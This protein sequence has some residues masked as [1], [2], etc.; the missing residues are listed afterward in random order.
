MSS[1]DQIKQ[2]R[3]ETGVSIAEC[4]KAIEETQG[5]LEKAKEILRMWGK[6]L[7]D[8]K[9]SREV[10][11]GMIKSYI[12]ANKKVGVLL[13]IRCESDFVVRNE[14]FEALAHEI[15]LQIA[16]MNP[17]FLS[18]GNIP[19]EVLEQEKKI[20][21]EQMKDSGKPKEIVDQIIDGKLKKFKQEKTL[22]AQAWIKDDTK[23]I[24]DLITDYIGKIGENIIVKKFVRYEI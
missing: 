13:D 14:N 2:L 4:K 5:D 22:L 10:K 15:C 1:L 12:H 24:T 6:S 17:E 11:A 3:E 8:K 7:A 19:A 18:E 23:T 9:Q 16:A 21:E 20:Y